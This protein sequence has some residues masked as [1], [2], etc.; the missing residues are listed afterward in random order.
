MINVY[1]TPY[2]RAHLQTRHAEQLTSSQPSAKKRILR[3]YTL[4]YPTLPYPDPSQVLFSV[5]ANNTT[6]IGARSAMERET[7]RE[8]FLFPSS[9]L[10][11]FGAA[12]IW[13]ATP[14]VLTFLHTRPFYC[15][16]TFNSATKLST[17]PILA[18]CRMLFTN[19]PDNLIYC[20]V[21]ERIILGL[22]S[23]FSQES[24]SFHSTKDGYYLSFVSIIFKFQRLY[25]P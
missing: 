18:V 10:L 22:T 12:Q 2:I 6:R 1:H 5:G 3:P 14:T 13:T 25:N 8:L 20:T 15:C 17:L 19:E 4:P 7:A 24:Q 21:Q 9:F 16:S 23:D 11:H